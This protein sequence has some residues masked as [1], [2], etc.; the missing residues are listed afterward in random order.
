VLNNPYK[1]DS[2]FIE[3]GNLNDTENIPFKQNVD[4]YFE[5]E[6]LPFTPDAWMDRT[7][8]KIGCEFPFTKLFYVYHPM[9]DLDAILADIKKLDEEADA[10]LEEI[11]LED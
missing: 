5:R 3:D 1:A 11:K 10:E 4:K 9:R 8:D 6:V 2:G 7:K